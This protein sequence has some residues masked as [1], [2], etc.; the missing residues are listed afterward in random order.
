M[1]LADLQEHL[2]RPAGRA[3]RRPAA[4][5]AARAWT[6]GGG[7]ARRVQDRGRQVDQAD[8]FV[9]TTLPPRNP[10]PRAISGMRM[11]PSWQ[12]RLYSALR[13]RKCEPW[14]LV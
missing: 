3:A 10:G 2:L 14:S 6:A 9:A 12:E 11:Q 8:Q 13:V 1:A 5:A 4:A 7:H